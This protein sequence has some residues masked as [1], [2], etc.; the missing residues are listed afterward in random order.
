MTKRRDHGEGTIDQRG[1]DRWR[2]RYRV[3]GK[4]YSVTYN[5]TLTDARKRLRELLRSGDTGQHVA[6]VKITLADWSATWLLMKRRKLSA[7][8]THERY[9]CLMRDHILPTLGKRPLQSLRS[10]EIEQLIATLSPGNAVLAYVILKA[11]LTSATRQQPPLIYV[12]PMIGV[13]KPKSTRP[14]TGALSMPMNGS[15]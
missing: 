7:R 1:P 4:R 3:D 10:A 15:A 2:L 8:R 9:S 5:G 14:T 12:N 6:P 11:C 13:D